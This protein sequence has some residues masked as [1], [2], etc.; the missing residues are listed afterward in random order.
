MKELEAA[1]IVLVAMMSLLGIIFMEYQLTPKD[2]VG[3][4]FNHMTPS[5]R[6]V[7]ITQIFFFITIVLCIGALVGIYL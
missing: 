7:T 1:A 5:A 2:K 6:V 4:G 3:L